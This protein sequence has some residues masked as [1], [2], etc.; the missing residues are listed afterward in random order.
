MGVKILLKA[1]ESFPKPIAFS[2]SLVYRIWSSILFPDRLSTV[3]K[4]NQINGDKL[5][6]KSCEVSEKVEERSVA[7]NVDPTL[8]S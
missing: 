1:S 7:R 2:C 6:K 5:D 4:N 3:F 8:L